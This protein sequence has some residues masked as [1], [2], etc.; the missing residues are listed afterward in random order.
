MSSDYSINMEKPNEISM[1]EYHTNLKKNDNLGIWRYI[2][3]LP[4]NTKLRNQ[5]GS[6]TF[7][8][9]GLANELGLKNL[10]I[11]FSGYCPEKNARNPTCS[12]KDLEASP[13]VAHM[14][15]NNQKNIVVASAGNTG[16]AFANLSIL[17][18]ME[19]HLIIPYDYR[20]EMWMPSEPN[21]RIHL[22]LVKGDYYDCIRYAKKYAQDNKL[23]LERGIFN[24]ARRDGLATV[25]YD[26]VMFMGKLPEDYF[27]GIGSGAGAIACWEAN[28][29]LNMMGYEGKTRLVISQNHPFTPIINA[30]NNRFK[31]LNEEDLKKEYIDEIYAKVLSNRNPPYSVV[32]GLYDALLDT[33]G[34]GISITNNE[35]KEGQSVFERTENIDIV[36]SAGV[37]VASLI[38]AIEEN[39]VGKWNSILL[40]IT[41]GGIENLKRDYKLHTIKAERTVG[42]EDV[43]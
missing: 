12:F 10:H 39:K 2:D 33:N 24:N 38:K 40:N 6:I 23:N 13:T 18:D 34:C 36:P 31:T 25:L 32:N 41:G 42:L 11:S 35:A 3:W 14:L 37:S 43:Y 15:E 8:S 4:C 17:T 30:W 20:D 5:V 7:K 16:K 26:A 9:E 21:D 19:T 27:Q 22:I 29:R 1:T 28:K